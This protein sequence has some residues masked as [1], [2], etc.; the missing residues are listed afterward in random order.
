MQL[1]TKISL[2][3]F[4][5]L[6]FL[7]VAFAWFSINDIR[8]TAA[9]NAKSQA[10]SAA[11]VIE[12]GLNAHMIN[13]T[14]DK[15]DEFL[16]QVASLESMKN[17]WI[18]RSLK[19]SKQ[20]GE[21]PLADEAHDGID[22]SVLESGEEVI[23]SKGGIFEDSTVR[24]SMPY[25]AITN[26]E[27]DCLSC[28]DVK[29]GDTL[30]VISLEMK[31]NDLKALNFQNILIGMT[32]LIVLFAVTGYILRQQVLIYFDRFAEIGKC[33]RALEDGDYSVRVSEEF[34]K[35]KDAASLNRLIEKFQSTL[36]NI[37]TNLSSTMSIDHTHNPLES[38]DNAIIQFNALQTFNELL[39]N[40]TNVAEAYNHVASYFSKQYNMDDINIIEYNPLSQETKV[41]FEKQQI[42]CDAISGCPAAR[43]LET[44]DSGSS[45]G[46]CP[47]MITPDEHYMCFPC[48]INTNSTLVISMISEKKN[49]LYS[50]RSN[51][52]MIHK[53]ISG[54]REQIGQH[55][56][57]SELKR[58]ERVDPISGLYNDQYLEERLFQIFRESKRAV[59]PYGVLVINVD[60]FNAVNESYGKKVGNDTL[61][62]IGRTL[63]D[64][65]RE[66]DL[67][68]RTHN[69][70]FVVMLFDCNPM[71]VSSVG[72]KIRSLFANKKLKSHPSGFILT[73]SIGSAIFPDHHKNPFECVEFARLAMDESKRE[74]GNLVT[75]FHSRLLEGNK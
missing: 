17:L 24:Y 13:G 63:L 31:T 62:V 16:K 49:G 30:G 29:V 59:I 41:V 51:Q 19:V 54:I 69:D 10:R 64:T 52:E 36:E 65:L 6:F 73:M 22:T 47:K 40:D 2:I 38:I 20:Y 3:L 74:G 9:L 70:E 25:K 23:E 57:L 11:K 42:L 72:E 8:N 56:M 66:S 1:K 37:K 68:V 46:A 75:K 45:H 44:I 7:F 34:S 48:I 60:K 67:I 14:M 55:Q 33:M 28:H 58:L 32:L 43:T 61:A 4:S 12:A 71:Y 35:D 27:I 39:H 15:R 50:A 21:G 53:T 5:S 18:V 26:K